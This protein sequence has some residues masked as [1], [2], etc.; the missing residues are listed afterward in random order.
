MLWAVD[1]Y[2]FARVHKIDFVPAM[3]VRLVGVFA[4]FSAAVTSD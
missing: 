1:S 4:A 3:H 2:T